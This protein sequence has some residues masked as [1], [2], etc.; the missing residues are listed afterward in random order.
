MECPISNNVPG[1]KDWKKDISLDRLLVQSGIFH[2][3]EQYTR[4][5]CIPIPLRHFCSEYTL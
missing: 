4:L 2:L 5:W 1:L 3:R